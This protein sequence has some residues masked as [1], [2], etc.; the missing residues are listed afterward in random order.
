MAPLQ[1]R[2]STSPSGLAQLSLCNIKSQLLFIHISLL[3]LSLGTHGNMERRNLAGSKTQCL[4]LVSCLPRGPEQF[5]SKRNVVLGHAS[6]AIYCFVSHFICFSCIKCAVVW[7]VY[8][9]FSHIHVVLVSSASG[10]SNSLYII[11][12]HCYEK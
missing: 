7:H 6:V 8:Q 1:R 5:K 10:F 12:R 3:V 4:V 11:H 9:L 2:Q